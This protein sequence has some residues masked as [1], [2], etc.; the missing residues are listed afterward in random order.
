MP[1]T[2]P[3][4]STEPPPR[5]DVP[6]IEQV[7]RLAVFQNA[8]DAEIR[9]VIDHGT[10]VQIPAGW[11]V[12]WEGTPA[13][14]AYLV[15]EGEVSVRHTGEVVATLGVGDFIGEMAIIQHRLRSATVVATTQ[16]L[17]LHFTDEAVTE[18]RATNE[19][20]RAAIDRANEAHS[21]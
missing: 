20:F 10:Y 4:S 5:G 17:G 21:A 3:L 2:R 8:S 15:L 7:R 12:I 9:E 1:D 16:V 13:E 14:K 6:S 19:P 11:S 18:L